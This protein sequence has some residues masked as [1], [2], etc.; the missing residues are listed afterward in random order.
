[1]PYRLANS[2][3]SFFPYSFASIPHGICSANYKMTMEDKNEILYPVKHFH[4]NFLKIGI[5][6][7]DF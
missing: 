1:M 2:V 6:A 3:T 7:V 4:F 5:E